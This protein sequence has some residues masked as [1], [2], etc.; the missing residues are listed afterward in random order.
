[1]LLGA[2]INAIACNLARYCLVRALLTAAYRSCLQSISAYIVMS[3]HRQHVQATWLQFQA[4]Y[5]EQR[6]SRVIAGMILQVRRRKRE[7][8][9]IE[10]LLDEL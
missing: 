8:S 2:K 3:H 10:D 4:E 6:L 1:M 9:N 7:C 5:S